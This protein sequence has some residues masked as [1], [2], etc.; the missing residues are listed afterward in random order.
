MTDSAEQSVAVPSAPKPLR[1]LGADAVV[2]E[3]DSCSIPGEAPA[4]S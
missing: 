1:L 3:G 2:C 4:Q